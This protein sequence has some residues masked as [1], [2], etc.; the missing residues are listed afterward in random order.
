M[1]HTPLDPWEWYI[2]IYLHLVDCLMANVGKSTSPMDPVATPGVLE[3]PGLIYELLGGRA[4]FFPTLRI[5]RTLQW[6]GLNE[7]V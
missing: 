4:C 3:R 5:P 2:Y 1:I 7:P 6:K